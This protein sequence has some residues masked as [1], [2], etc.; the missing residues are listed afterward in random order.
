MRESKFNRQELETAIRTRL[1]PDG[2]V[3]DEVRFVWPDQGIWVTIDAWSSG[4]GNAFIFYDSFVSEYWGSE[5]IAPRETYV[6]KS[7]QD[8]L[9]YIRPD[10]Y[11]YNQHVVVPLPVQGYG[12][13]SMTKR[14]V[15]LPEGCL[16]LDR[17]L[18]E[19]GREKQVLFVS[20]S[21]NNPQP[22]FNFG[23]PTVLSLPRQLPVAA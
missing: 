5:P 22:R 4:V 11:S 13:I 2:T 6:P 19:H 9:D 12:C 14:L 3:I 20:T 10:Q 23:C 21:S 7:R 1:L 18:D 8:Y 17:F 15:F 16:L